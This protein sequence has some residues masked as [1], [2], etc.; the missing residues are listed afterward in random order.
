MGLYF[1]GELCVVAMKNDANIREELTCQFKMDMRNLRNFYPS[2]QK[3]Q[4]SAL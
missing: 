1:T 3:F 4:K 2:T